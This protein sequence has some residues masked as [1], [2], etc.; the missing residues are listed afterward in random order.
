MTSCVL[1]LLVKRK[2]ARENSSDWHMTASR[3][4]IARRAERSFCYDGFFTL[5]LPSSSEIFDFSKIQKNWRI[6][7]VTA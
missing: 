5:P 1:S 7:H 2:P 4:I 3:T 6:R